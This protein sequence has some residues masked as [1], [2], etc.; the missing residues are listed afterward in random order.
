M[1]KFAGSWSG[2]VFMTSTALDI[3]YSF[4]F[5]FKQKLHQ[6]TMS[7]AFYFILFYFFLV[8]RTT[9]CLPSHGLALWVKKT[10]HPRSS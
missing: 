2:N 1:S 5:V 3:C 6:L 4:F 9:I 8:E 7:Q 10:L